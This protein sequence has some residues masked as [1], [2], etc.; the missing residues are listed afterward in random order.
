MPIWQILAAAIRESLGK[1]MLVPSIDFDRENAPD[2]P[3]FSKNEH[4]EKPGIGVDKNYNP[5]KTGKRT[6]NNPAATSLINNWQ[7]LYE[8]STQTDVEP[9]NDGF[10]IGGKAEDSPQQE[11]FKADVQS[12]CFQLNNRYIVSPVKSGLMIIDQH[13]AHTKVLYENYLSQLD[14]KSVAS[15]NVLFPEVLNL[16]PANHAIMEQLQPEM[17]KMGFSLAYLGGNDWSINAV[18][19]GKEKVDYKDTILQVIEAVTQGGKSISEHVLQTI[20]LTVAK[21][22][23]TPYGKEL[24]S[25]EMETLLANLLQLPSPN[26]TPDGKTVIKVITIDQIEKIF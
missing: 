1:F 12:T 4:Y 14:G 24:G 5:F 16:S 13:R 22:A 20:A 8:G 6:E 15:Q 3:V 11:L 25:D 21:S 26:Y 2:I 23:A 10:S 7:K 19:A 9:D 18:P 17:E